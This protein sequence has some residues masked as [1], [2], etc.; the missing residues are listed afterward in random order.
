MEGHRIEA[1][2][3][4]SVPS[5]RIMTALSFL[6]PIHER[7]FRQLPRMIGQTFV[8][9][10]TKARI[11][12]LRGH[13]NHAITNLNQVL[14]DS[15]STQAFVQP[16]LH[17]LMIV[18]KEH[19]YSR[20]SFGPDIKF[21]QIGLSSFE[22]ARLFAKLSK[23][24]GVTFE[25][26]KNIDKDMSLLELAQKLA[27]ENSNVSSASRAEKSRD[28][29]CWGTKLHLKCDALSVCAM[30]RSIIILTD[31]DLLIQSNAFPCATIISQLNKFKRDSTQLTYDH[32]YRKAIMECEFISHIVNLWPMN[33]TY[34]EKP[35]NFGPISTFLTVLQDLVENQSIQLISSPCFITVE[36]YS[37]TSTLDRGSILQSWSDFAASQLSYFTPINI[38]L[39]DIPRKEGMVSCVEKILGYF[40][41][42]TQYIR[43]ML[44]SGT[45]LSVCK[46]HDHLGTYLPVNYSDPMIQFLIEGSNYRDSIIGTSHLDV[47]YEIQGLVDPLQLQYALDIII[48]RHSALRVI[49]HGKAYIELRHITAHVQYI[50][51]VGNDSQ[52]L[53]RALSHFTLHRE[54]K[55][56]QGPLLRVVAIQASTQR[57]VYAIIV[58]HAIVDMFSMNIIARDLLSE[59]EKCIRCSSGLSLCTITHGFHPD[60]LPFSRCHQAPSV[61]KIGSKLIGVPRLC[62]SSDA[63]GIFSRLHSRRNGIEE[64]FAIC[65]PWSLER[66]SY[67]Y[68]LMRTNFA[69]TPFELFITLLSAHFLNRRRESLQLLWTSRDPTLHMGNASR[70]HSLD[71]KGPQIESQYLSFPA[72]L[73]H[74]Q[75]RIR[76]PPDSQVDMSSDQEDDKSLLVVV[77]Q[78]YVIN[79]ITSTRCPA[80]AVFE[81]DGLPIPR[82]MPSKFDLYLLLDAGCE[83]KGYALHS[84]HIDSQHIQ[85]FMSE[86]D[87]TLCSCMEH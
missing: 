22:R 1:L 29:F 59:Y 32:D 54:L 43:R 8:S 41:H 62:I 65:T 28:I 20:E 19:S 6:A 36:K 38:F 57:W 63:G 49:P 72:L 50:I 52:T 86:V 81:F 70:I 58:H 15:R 13:F 82:L 87:F 24:F 75:S 74:V 44:I 39:T 46:A 45:D 47:Y 18:L 78:N 11:Q 60:L 37:G 73:S 40:Q 4:V 85:N 14:L 34:E 9:S 71:L 42:E 26:Q 56:E 33:S 64:R 68:T 17:Y 55:S 21:S 16:I 5:D 51:A 35:N 27:G 31:D 77:S 25:L 80:R 61:A 84:S 69:A 10:G 2:V 3:C 7:F 48:E 30:K 23:Q 12:H 67:W 66:T 76:Y 53:K 79:D 83:P